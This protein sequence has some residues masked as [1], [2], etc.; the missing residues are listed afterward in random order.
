MTKKLCHCGASIPINKYSSIQAKECP[1]CAYLTALGKKKKPVKGEKKAST[2]NPKSLA[3]ANADR[4]FSRY[5]R[6][7]YAYQIATDG[8]PIC[9]CIVT[10]VLKAAKNMDNGHCFSRVFKMTRYEEDNCRPQNP[11]SNRFSGEA[12]HYTFIDNLTAEIGPERFARIDQLRRGEGEDNELFYN[13]MSEKYHK[14][15]NELVKDKGIK[16]WW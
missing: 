7:K 6:I 9:K 11:S 4:W 10:G 16:K 1:K 5:I 8:T 13:E 3:M 12:D 2:K 14:L 15:V